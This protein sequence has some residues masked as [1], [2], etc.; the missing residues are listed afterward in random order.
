MEEQKKFVF[1]DVEFSN[2]RK[3][4][5]KL[6]NAEKI[7][8]INTLL[9]AHEKEGGLARIYPLFICMINSDREY[10]IYINLN[11]VLTFR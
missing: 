4:T 9:Q 11:H 3:E 2:G 8:F 6:A 7:K 1:M 10:T 5:Y